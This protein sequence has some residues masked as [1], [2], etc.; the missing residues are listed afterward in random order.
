VQH[1]I[2]VPLDG[3][4]FSEAILPH[5]VAL[6]HATESALILLQVLEPMYEP[7]YGA[8]GISEKQQ[9]EQLARMRDGQ[10]A[11][12]DD[13]LLNIAKPLRAEGLEVHTEVIEGNDPTA[14][15]VLRAEQDPQL[16]L[17]AMATHGRSYVLRWLFG[18]IT[19]EVVQLA[20]VPLL[21]LRPHENGGPGSTVTPKT[22]LY[23]TVIVPLDGSSFAEQALEQALLLASAVSATLLLVSI[24]PPPN[25][26]AVQKDKETVSLM[27]TLRELETQRRT[28]YLEHLAQP[29]SKQGVVVHT[30]VATGH[31]AEEILHLSTQHQ[32]ALLVMTTHGRSGLQRL[33]VG[34]V[35]LKVVQ[36]VHGPVLL[37]RGRPEEKKSR[38]A[39]P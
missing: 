34:S 22:L 18:S 11:S 19:A 23:Q 4:T 38:M 31:P 32:P 26:F 6:A 8:L 37:V 3:S 17:I 27:S 1:H 33:F 12:I 2:L 36:G 7:I 29:L 30:H 20:P 25:D 5:A 24:L 9:E 28:R 21:L 14:Y 16:L 10:L 35:A 13:Y 15:I 39:V